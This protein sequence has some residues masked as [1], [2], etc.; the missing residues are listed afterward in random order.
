MTCCSHADCQKQ[1]EHERDLRSVRHAARPTPRI[2]RR[3]YSRAAGH[4]LQRR[5]VDEVATSG[6]ESV[7]C[8]SLA[9]RGSL[10][11]DLAT[12][13]PAPRNIKLHQNPL[14]LQYYPT[15]FRTY[16]T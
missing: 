5:V 16:T 4:R 3:H 10:A 7:L 15:Y 9:A 13:G 2:R 11:G 6:S 14:Y 1:P 12:T 8:P